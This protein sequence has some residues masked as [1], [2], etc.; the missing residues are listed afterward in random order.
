MSLPSLTSDGKEFK[1]SVE[2]VLQCNR[3]DLVSEIIGEPMLDAGDDEFCYDLIY[4]KRTLKVVKE[5]PFIG[6]FKDLKVRAAVRLGDVTAEA[7][8]LH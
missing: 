6:L 8:G 7:N 1:Q 2:S 4:R 5:I 3:D